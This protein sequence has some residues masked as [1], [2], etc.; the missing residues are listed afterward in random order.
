MTIYIHPMASHTHSRLIYKPSSFK[1]SLE[2]SKVISVSEIQEN[3]SK[4]AVIVLINLYPAHVNTKSFIK[5][6]AAEVY[7]RLIKVAS[8]VT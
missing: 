6:A 5:S 7:L 2:A 3:V 1:M 8:Y 4:N